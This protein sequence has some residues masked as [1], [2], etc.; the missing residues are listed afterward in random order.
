MIPMVDMA[1]LLASRGATVSFV[2]TPVNA[3]RIKPVIDGASDAGL[4]I[5]FVE[6]KLPCEEAGVPEGCES[7]DLLPSVDFY[8]PLFE[9]IIMLREPLKLYLEQAKPRASCMVTDYCNWWTSEV[10]RE[11]N[12]ARL[13][14]HGPSC[15]Y[16]L[17][18]RNIHRSKVYERVADEHECVVVP[19][20]PQ[21]IEITR[22]GLV[23]RLERD[24]GESDGGGG[25]GGRSVD[26]H[27]PR[28]GVRAH[29][30]LHRVHKEDGTAHRTVVPLQQGCQEQGH[31]GG[32]ALRRGA[33]DIALAGL[34][35]AEV[36][37][38][39]QLWQ[40]RQ[41]AASA[42][43]RGGL[44]AGGIRPAVRLGD[45][46]GGEVHGGGEMDVRRVRG[47]DEGEEPGNHRVGAAG[48]D[49]VAPG[50][51]GVHDAL[52][53]EF[54]SGG[55]IVGSADDN[56]AALCRPVPQREARG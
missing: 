47:E 1:R 25:S 54:D 17:S 35:G 21:R 2:T 11:L 49:T 19:G 4:P 31:K 41:N 32:Q 22:A 8:K 40:P 42:A 24:A 3:A 52:R 16:L 39:R 46:G 50:G 12:I 29:C 10:A 51:G 20:L 37:S 9:A 14:F 33:S 48:G 38:L 13:V 43:D 28:I 44:R 7:F 23:C 34:D 56:V 53:L 55:D 26:K 6:F 18:S 15:F 36:G 30:S 5:R 27:L 45:Q